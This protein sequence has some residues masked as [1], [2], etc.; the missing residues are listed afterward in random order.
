M[1]SI[2]PGAINLYSQIVWSPYKPARPKVDHLLK[3]D[4][5]HHGIVSDQARR[6]VGKAIDYLLYLSND[7]VL[8]ATAHGKSYNFKIAFITLTLPSK[9]IH[10]DNEI[11]DQCLNQFLIEIRQRYNVKNYL[12]RAEKQKNK[13]VHFHIL[14]DKFIPWSELRDR[15]NRIINK[16][17]YV[18]NYRTEMK[19]F[20]ANGFNIRKDLLQHWDYQK[21]IKAYQKGKINDWQSPNST[22]VHSLYKIQSIRKYIT[23]YC[24]KNDVNSEVSGRMWGC[25][26]ELSDI[27]GAAI[28]ADV[29]IKNQLDEIIKEYKPKVYN[30]EFFSVIHISV[31]KLRNTKYE[32]LFRIFEHYL[33]DTFPDPIQS[34][35]TIN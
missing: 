25:N 33:S 19:Q 18:E 1:L 32:Q 6:K 3:S 35:L 34:Q 26:Y 27:K 15:W 5:K 14:V 7:K 31:D 17:G 2:H 23:K 29:E 22:D 16:L 13:N 11:K 4:K 28:I 9:Q 21:Q 30:G 8:P 20:H 10:S 12:W 24:T